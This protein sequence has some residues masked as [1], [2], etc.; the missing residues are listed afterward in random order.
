MAARYARSPNIQS[1]SDVTYTPDITHG[2]LIPTLILPMRD[3]WMTPRY[4]VHPRPAPSC[5]LLSEFDCTTIL[6]SFK[7]WCRE[8]SGIGRA[9]RRRL[10]ARRRRRFS[11]R[12]LRRTSA[13]ARRGDRPTLGAHLRR[14]RLDQKSVADPF[15]IRRRRGNGDEFV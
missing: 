9:D 5:A 8:S 4:N 3:P 1:N 14:R 15:G 11:T 7:E 12:K 10:S 13:A 6:R 2:Q